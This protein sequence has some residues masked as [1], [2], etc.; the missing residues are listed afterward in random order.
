MKNEFFKPTP[1]YKE[2]VLLDAIEKNPKVTQRELSE[3]L[4]GAVS[5]INQYIDKYEKEGLLTKVY[6]STKIVEYRITEKGIDRRKLL[7]I[8]YLKAA[9]LIHKDA[10]EEIVNFLKKISENG[11]KKIILYGAGVVT[12]IIIQTLNYDNSLEIQ[13]VGIV[14]DDISK[15]GRKIQNFYIQPVNN[16][17]D[18][19]HDGILV[20]SYLHHTSIENK[21]KE[22]NYNASKIIS[23]F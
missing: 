1:V 20:S 18:I 21:L 8:H 5:M 19:T 14:D 13:I 6:T 23:L 15:Y 3:L 9:Q 2:Y 16:I 12:D 17:F 7:N 22:S 10:R 11:F 4:G